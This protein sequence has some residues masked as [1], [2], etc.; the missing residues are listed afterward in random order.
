[1]DPLHERVARTALAAIKGYGFVLAGGYAVQAHGLLER[2]SEDVDLFTDRGDREGFAAAVEA[3]LAAW[4]GDG[5]HAVVEARYDTFARFTVVD[6][7]RRSTKVEFGYDW[8]SEPP[9]QLAVGPVL[10]RDDAVANKVCAVFSRALPRDYIDVY[11]AIATG[12]YS[13]DRLVE[14][15]AAHDPGF[16]AAG[17]GQA[18]AASS[19]YDDSAYAFYGLDSEQVAVMRRALLD[20]AEA[21]GR[22]LRGGDGATR[23]S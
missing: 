14:L 10:H 16:D 9:A 5:L 13:R 22:G 12:G 21:L 11:A 19:R 18:L 17:F 1:V 15:A 20:W 6:E 2:M 4:A 23:D 7:Q 8:R 3:A